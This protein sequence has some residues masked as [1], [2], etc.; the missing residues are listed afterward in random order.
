MS[1][2][3]RHL[4]EPTAAGPPQEID[5]A[6][7]DAA[8][9]AGYGRLFAL[10]DPQ[11]GLG[12]L[13]DLEERLGTDTR[14][15]LPEPDEAP[16]ARETVGAVPAG[17]VGRYQDRGE[18]ARGGMGVIIRSRDT[19]LG[20][21]VAM[22]VLHPRHASDAA[23][24]RRFV[25][26]AQIA[27]QLQHP[28]I[29]QVYELGMQ[30]DRLPYF[31]MKLIKGTT[32]QE[33]LDRRANPAD[34]RRRFLGVFEHV[35]QAMAYAHARGVIHRDLKPANVM[36]GNFGEVQIVDWGLA[37][38]TGRRA[39]GGPGATVIETAPGPVP[40]TGTGSASLAGSVMGTP[41]YMPPEQARG[42]VDRLDER[43]DVFA[44]GAIL[45]EIITGKPPYGGD[46]ALE[47]AREARVGPALERIEGCSADEELRGLARSCLR[48]DP[49]ERP[50]NGGAVAGAVT[51]YLTS[52]EE[53]A[54][55]ADRAA[56]A[57][58]ATAAHERRARRQTM[59][60]AATVVLVL[61]IGAGGAIGVM[62]DRLRKI[63]ADSEKANA[64][65]AEATGLLEQAR[66]APVA[67]R[68]SWIA[69]RAA[70]A[71]M[72]GLRAAARLDD[73]TQGRVD[74]FLD[75]LSSADRDRAMVERIEDL[76]IAGA[77][78][79]DRESW[80]L[81]EGRIREAFREYGIDVQTLPRE[82]VAARIRESALAP[83]LTDGL[84]LWIATAAHLSGMGETLYP[85]EDLR[86]W[87]DV[88]DQADP[89]PYRTAVRRQVYAPAPDREELSRLAG[90]PEFEKA[91]P[92]TLSWLGNAMLRA[93][94]E[95]GS[96]GAY[97]RALDLHP[98]DCMLHFDYALAL[99]ARG[100]DQD[101]IGYY[102]RGLGI[103]PQAG[104]IW[105]SLGQACR[106]TGDRE[107]AIDAFSKS[108]RYQP[109]HAPSHVDLGRALAEAGRT[110]EALEAYRTAIQLR[111]DLAEAHCFMGLALQ[112]KGRLLE[113]LV[114]LER[115]H[116][117][118]S[119]DPSWPYPSRVWVNT[120][121][122]RLMDAKKG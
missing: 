112:E 94:D 76:V 90:S 6:D 75:Q 14:I 51:S 7:L 27:G 10:G 64:A 117:L 18:I 82:Q 37:K 19:D 53:R 93:G 41:A 69:L 23:M 71:H 65:L 63:S 86:R 11:G 48:S 15:V 91:L 38:L 35:C 111:P 107:G 115:G 59:A 96:D 5:G 108:V 102:N 57:A 33:L 84:E 103:R 95:E 49:A 30:A 39:A 83:Q 61:V 45:C 31:T 4:A 47:Q 28:G 121:L 118:G 116:D 70:G 68:T 110:D 113:A 85:V 73:A 109:D 24:V 114:S 9:E 1:E 74:A 62:N 16:S 22:K 32:L 119:K 2:K 87:V 89:D 106:R 60:L 92:R 52:V 29:L 99:A 98:G 13:T 8:L 12:V 78:H 81:M 43:C 66:E 79:E 21:D 122:R 88:L 80:R 58:R 55:A 42:E 25:E 44:L 100:K 56:A 67:D 36:V 120:C 17:R 40:G 34:G 54:R 50:A 105:R 104:G 3:D 77:T 46:G 97:R 26:E 72:A 20:R 101:A